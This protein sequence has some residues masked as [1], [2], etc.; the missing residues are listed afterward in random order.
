M[1]KKYITRLV[2]NLHKDVRAIEKCRD[3]L[4]KPGS[5]LETIYV[6]DIS[7]RATDRIHEIMRELFHMN[8]ISAQQF[9]N[10]LMS[11]DPTKI[12]VLKY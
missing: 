2:K 8:Q 7:A 11:D 1:N 12:P 6:K 5:F 4:E 3:M 9:E 10:F